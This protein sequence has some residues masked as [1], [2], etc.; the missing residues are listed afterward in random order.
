MASLGLIVAAIFIVLG[1]ILFM[2]PTGYTSKEGSLIPG[3]SRSAG[4][5]MISN[6]IVG[7]IIIF[8]AYAIIYTV[9]LVLAP[10]AT[11]RFG[12]ST[13]GFIIN[14]PAQSPFI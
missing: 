4:K 3:A 6:A 7:L 8:L 12:I 10:D 11:A 9:I 1:A 14:C 2:I 13:G 5:A